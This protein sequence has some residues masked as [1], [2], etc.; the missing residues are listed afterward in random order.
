MNEAIVKIFQ[1]WGVNPD[2][3][4]WIYWFLVA[5]ILVLII[6]SVNTICFRGVIP[7]IRKLTKTTRSKWD[8]ILLNDNLLRDFVHLF[9]PLIIALLLPVAFSKE[10]SVLEFILKVNTIYTIVMVSKTLCSFLSTLY[11]L[12]SNNDKFRNHPLKGVYQMLKIA[13][14]CVA[15]IIILSYGACDT[16]YTFTYN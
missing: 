15:L 12:S 10:N 4:Y 16:N 11:N 5:I 2:S 9:P 8:D 6:Y 13:V 3:M 7:M 14:I 1:H